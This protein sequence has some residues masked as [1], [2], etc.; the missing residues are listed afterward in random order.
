MK[1]YLL[2]FFFVGN[3]FVG[4]AQI[5]PP[6]FEWA[7]S[8]G[9]WEHDN[10]QDMEVDAKGNLYVVGHFNDFIC[11]DSICLVA[12]SPE[13]TDIYVAKYDSMGTIIWAKSFGGKGL[14]EGNALGIDKFENLYIAGAFSDTTLFGSY[15]LI[16]SDTGVYRLLSPDLFLAKLNPSG[17]VLWVKQG[18]GNG[19]DRL[20]QLSVGDDEIWVAGRGLTTEILFDSVYLKNHDGRNFYLAK[21]TFS[22]D[23]QSAKIIEAP[24]DGSSYGL[25]SLALDQNSG[26]FVAGWVSSLMEIDDDTIIGNFLLK[27]DF[28]GKYLWSKSFGNDVDNLVGINEITT[29][30]DN[31]LYIT[32]FLSGE[33]HFDTIDISTGSSYYYYLARYSSDGKAM[34]VRPAGP[35]RGFGGTSIYYNRGSVY[36]TGKFGDEFKI[37]SVVLIDQGGRRD[38]IFVLR[39][40]EHGEL[41]WGREIGSPATDWAVSITGELSGYLYVAG[42]FPDYNTIVDSIVLSNSNVSTFDLWVGRMTQDSLAPLEIPPP[43]GEWVAY[44]NPF[45]TAINVFGDFDRGETTIEIFNLA[46]QLVHRTKSA[47][48]FSQNRLLIT[49]P[50]LAD[51]MYILNLSQL[52]IQQTLKILKQS[53]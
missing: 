24:A 43:I 11:F 4:L 15:Q 17:E 45:S 18:K 37:G 31:S 5:D 22:G 42:A 10:L 8:F 41:I 38:D 52:G 46:G 53:M 34:W 26:L 1:S 16:A 28:S 50:S 21:Y 7:K 25:N 6:T 3:Y 33:V 49:L 39:H 20:T 32:G 30:D 36:T 47:V 9:G 27:L 40:D 2:I 19:P 12:S 13:D 35:T 14:D 44:P 51:G 23:L 29:S 48:E